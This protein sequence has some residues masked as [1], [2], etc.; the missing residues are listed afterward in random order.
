MEDDKPNDRSSPEPAH[1]GNASREARNAF[2]KEASEESGRRDTMLK[3][4]E[5][6]EG[7]C[8]VKAY[9]PLQRPSLAASHRIMAWEKHGD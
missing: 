9:N 5:L 6:E 2:L 4:K 3:L 8:I 1:N 7:N